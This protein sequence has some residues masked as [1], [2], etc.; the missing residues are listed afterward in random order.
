M[1]LH[2]TLSLAMKNGGVSADNMVLYYLA[3]HGAEARN[4]NRQLSAFRYRQAH[5]HRRGIV[6]LLRFTEGVQL[7]G[8]FH[9]GLGLVV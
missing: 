1:L 4:M 6:L 3:R 2:T 7:R 5:E 9:F 8:M